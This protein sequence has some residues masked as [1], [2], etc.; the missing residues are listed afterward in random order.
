MINNSIVQSYGQCGIL[1]A[2]LTDPLS[3]LINKITRTDVT[4]KPNSIGFYYNQQGKYKIILFNTYDNYEVPWLKK[5]TLDL[6]L[7]CPFT[8]RITLYPIE[9]SVFS[10]F[11]KTVEKIIQTSYKHDK[12]T[13]YTMLL[14]NFVTGQEY[15]NI[16]TGYSL[17]NKCL[18]SLMN[19]SCNDMSDLIDNIITCELIQ[20]EIILYSTKS[21]LDYEEIK[22]QVQKENSKELI[23]I[24]ASFMDLFLN[25]SCF[26]QRIITLIGQEKQEELKP[27][28]SNNQ[29]LVKLGNFIKA[30]L[31][32]YE[33][34]EDIIINV[35]DLIAIYN[36]LNSGSND[37]IQSSIELVSKNS[38]VILPKSNKDIKPKSIIIPMFPSNLGNLTEEQLIDM[39]IYIDSLKDTRFSWLQNKIITELARRNIII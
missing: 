19:V 32:N 3:Q 39:L 13:I 22:T 30:I 1:T 7:S 35:N 18:L 15:K 4:Y 34:G 31:Y 29:S 11:S 27:Q 23:K 9:S 20:K 33:N 17:V 6:L 14:L 12:S 38:V 8:E 16:E 37:P 10:K 25:S 24:S 2:V 36:D 28:S 21:S 5:C 26:Q